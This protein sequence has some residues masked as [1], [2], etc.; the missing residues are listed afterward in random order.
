MLSLA[1]TML[2]MARVEVST[3]LVRYPNVFFAVVENYTL[4]QNT[5]HLRVMTADANVVRGEIP[6]TLWLDVKRVPVKALVRHLF[7]ADANGEIA[8]CAAAQPVG[9]ADFAGKWNGLQQAMGGNAPPPPL[10]VA[11]VASNFCNKR[12]ATGSTMFARRMTLYEDGTIVVEGSGAVL[13]RRTTRARIDEIRRLL[14]VAERHKRLNGWLSYVPSG[15]Q[16]LSLYAN[17]GGQWSA[18]PVYL[19][20][21]A[22]G[23][24][25]EYL[26]PEREA[27]VRAILRAAGDA[28]AFEDCGCVP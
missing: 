27:V 5:G 17:R 10:P 3:L 18:G 12:T 1:M 25:H 26:T 28:A 16:E 21:T 14:D 7:F 2:V 13:V 22:A 4:D 23:L 11:R 20:C 24:G 15:I 19:A 6:K 8:E 9:S